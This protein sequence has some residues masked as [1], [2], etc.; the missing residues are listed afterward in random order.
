MKKTII[1]AI[2]IVFC[3][4]LKAGKE[5]SHSLLWKTLTV[6][7]KEIFLTAYIAGQ[8]DLLMQIEKQETPSIKSAHSQFEKISNILQ[9]NINKERFDLLIEWIDIFFRGSGNDSHSISDALQFANEHV[10]S[11]QKM[12]GID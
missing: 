2:T 3:V 8:H 9:E 7:Q 4:F 1:L 5:V 6:V 10:I 11:F 12:K